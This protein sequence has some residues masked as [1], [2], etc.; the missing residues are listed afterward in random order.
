MVILAAVTVK[1]LRKVILAAVAVKLVD[2]H[3][4]CW[5]I[6]VDANSPKNVTA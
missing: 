6:S 4:T 2:G 1:E 3:R 5:I